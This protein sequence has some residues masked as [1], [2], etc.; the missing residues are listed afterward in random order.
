MSP[1]PELQRQ[2]V[3]WIRTNRVVDALL[4]QHETDPSGHCRVC[5]SEG[6]L[7]GRMVGPCTTRLAAE[8]A[9]RQDRAALDKLKVWE[10]GG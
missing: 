5:R 9:Q 7:S 1:D 10:V 2:L 4:W 6:M 8:E 3:K